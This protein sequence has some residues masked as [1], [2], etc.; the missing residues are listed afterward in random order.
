MHHSSSLLLHAALLGAWR[1]VAAGPPNWRTLW[2]SVGPAGQ[3]GGLHLEARLLDA[4][5]DG[6]GDAGAAWASSSPAG[7]SGSRV[8][9]SVFSELST[10]PACVC[11]PLD[12]S[13]PRSGQLLLKTTDGIYSLLVSPPMLA[14]GIRMVLLRYVAEYSAAWARTLLLHELDSYAPCS[15]LVH[16][17][18]PLRRSSVAP[19]FAWLSR[20]PAFPL[21]GSPRSMD[22][23]PFVI[24]CLFRFPYPCVTVGG[25]LHAIWLDQ[26]ISVSNALN[27]ELSSSSIAQGS[28]S[29]NL[30]SA[31]EAHS[32]VHVLRLLRE[33]FASLQA[34][35]RLRSL[36]S[37]LP[38][39]LRVSL[40]SQLSQ[41]G[42]RLIAAPDFLNRC[43]HLCTHSLHPCAVS[44]AQA[45][46]ILAHELFHMAEL[47]ALADNHPAASLPFLAHSKRS[48]QNSSC[49]SHAASRALDGIKENRQRHQAR[50]TPGF[51]SAYAQ[52]NGCEE[53]AELFAAMLTQ[54]DVVITQCRGDPALSGKTDRLLDFLDRVA[55]L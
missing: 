12:A 42:E 48:N 22:Q 9:V 3:L 19:A 24:L 55:L 26:P 41:D 52:V 46:W 13:V 15:A 27:S 2:E 10:D 33:V 34:N 5:P 54:P 8:V 37:L 36:L 23:Q 45:A 39:P 53:R 44:H 43:L 1:V 7:Y 40:V 31:F 50:L 6:D 17:G 18:R 28:E 47:F 29:F 21:A 38:L 11:T 4:E 51:I 20:L 49:A 16:R 25:P 30:P 32:S 14:N 35:P